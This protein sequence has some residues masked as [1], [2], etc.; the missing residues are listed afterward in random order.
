MI[1]KINLKGNDIEY[2]LEIKPV[3]NINLRIKADKSVYVSANES[4][5]EE[6]ISE[7][8]ISRAD[9]ILDALKKYY[10]MLRYAAVTKSFVSGES[11]KVFGHNRRL[12]VDNAPNNYVTSDESY[13]YLYCKD[14]SD[15]TTKKRLLNNWLQKQLKAGVENICKSV[16]RKFEK[17]ELDFPVI[18]YRNMVSRWGSCQPKRKILTF[19]Y[20]LINV[21]VAC[22][23]Y[24]VI[25]EFT[26]FLHPNHSKK[27]Y[28]QL[29]MFMPDWRERKK[30]LDKEV[31]QGL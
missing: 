30:I 23:E 20:A 12:V 14:V 13:I 15:T 16:Y 8:L 6:T 26:H 29:S 27:F 5:T 3:K 2:D 31:V 11:F 21:P 4:I 18:R 9:Y 19:N 28:L 1:R 7:F 10:E 25:H 22:V 17:Y 24:V